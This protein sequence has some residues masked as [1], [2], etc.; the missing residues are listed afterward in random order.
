MVVEQH[1]E[2][3]L[4]GEFSAHKITIAAGEKIAITGMFNLYVSPFGDDVVNSGIEEISPFKTPQR[5]IQ[6]LSDKTITESGFVTINI[7]AG[8]YD[9]DETLLFDHPQGERIA[10]IGAEPEILMLQYVQYYKTYGLTAAGYSGFYSGV[11]HEIQIG[12]VRPNDSTTFASIV[13]G[14][15]TEIKNRTPGY[16]VV[17]EDY[18]LAFD[19][20]YNPTYYYG[21]YPR[22]PRNNI[23]RQSAILGSHTL[24]GVT[25]G[26]LTI[27]SSIRDDWFAIPIPPGNTAWARMYGNAYYGSQFDGTTADCSEVVSNSWL[28]TA[29]QTGR[30]H[31]LSTVP[32]GY[33]G[34]ASTTGIIIGSTANFAGATFPTGTLSAGF[35]APFQY[36]SIA[37]GGLSGSYYSFTGP[38]GSLMNDAVRFGNNYHSHMM[39]ING[40]SGAGHSGSWGSVNTNTITVK[41]IPTVFRRQGTIMSVRSGGLRKVKNIFFDGK[42]MPI[43]YGLLGN[44]NRYTNGYSNKTAIHATG[45][46]LGEVVDNEPT[47]L[48]SGLCKNVG[49]KDF[50]VGVFCDRSTAGNLGRIAISNC[51]YGM[52]SNNG[53][54]VKTFASTSTGSV[55][56]FCA[57]NASSLETNRCFASFSG[58]SLIEIR[59]KDS[60]GSTFDFDSN[61]FI[62]GQTY[63]TP[64]GKVKGT[65]FSWDAVDKLLTLAV[66]TGLLEGKRRIL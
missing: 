28:N 41:I 13:N 38:A 56:G 34:K 29:S 57:F 50:H 36:T 19:P 12:C 11:T 20:D 45:S 44:S 51:S 15:D 22:N 24:T 37:T 1:Y 39:H 2:D 10:L 32:V 25:N 35:T 66:R 60:V 30:G 4:M 26:I 59:M 3:N 43:F 17:I 52:I 46:K 54:A 7:A 65:V 14:T 5:A 27:E 40:T 55:F 62:A 63:A 42:A 9:F 47:D 31:Y 64:D 33:Y 18:D 49:I 23:V 6:F 58:Q 21:S 48:E 53:S 8:I 16:G 61:S